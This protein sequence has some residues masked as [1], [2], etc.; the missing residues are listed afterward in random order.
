MDC[1]ITDPPYGLGTKIP[2]PEQVHAYLNGDLRL[3]TD[4]T[5]SR[6]SREFPVILTRW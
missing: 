1:V 2:T 4:A 5:G 3:D 6:G